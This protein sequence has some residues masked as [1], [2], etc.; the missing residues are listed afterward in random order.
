MRSLPCRRSTRRTAPPVEPELEVPEHEVRFARGDRRYRVRGLDRNLSF[1]QLRVN[2]WV[3]R[4]GH[5]RSPDPRFSG[6]FVD[7]LGA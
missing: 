4:E 3:S 7:T 2:L 6:F 1:N 5:D